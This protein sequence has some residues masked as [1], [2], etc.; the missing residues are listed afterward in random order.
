M[1]I[2]IVNSFFIMP[3]VRSVTL[4]FGL[5]AMALVGGCAVAEQDATQVGDQFQRGLQ[6]QGRIIPNNPTTDSFGSE[7]N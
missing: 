3:R 2:A 5:L 1:K 4:F 7:Y 6:G